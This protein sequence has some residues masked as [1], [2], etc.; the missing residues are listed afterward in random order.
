MLLA[1]ALHGD[2]EL[3]RKR[4]DDGEPD[5]VQA[6]RDLVAAA[7]ELAAR[8][9][10]CHHHFQRR[11]APVLHDVDRDAPSV[12]RHRSRVV[13]VQGD[14]DPVAEAGQGF[15]YGVVDDLVDQMMETPVIG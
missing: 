11:L 10:Q 4:V 12:V 3:F 8:V 1:V 5:P 6:A 15:V 2:L 14:L 9:E 7:P 13:L